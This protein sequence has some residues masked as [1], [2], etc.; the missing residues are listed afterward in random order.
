MASYLV[1][2]GA[3]FIGSHLC[4]ALVAAGHRVSVLDDFSSG[5]PQNID[6]LVGHPRFEYSAGSVTDPALLAECLSR[7][8]AVFHLAAVV[9]MRLVMANPRRTLQINLDGSRL[10]LDLASR[11]GRRVLLASS[12]EVYG[13]SDRLPFRE[14]AELELGPP[15]DGRWVYASSKIAAERLALARAREESLAVS[16]VRLFNTTGP[17]QSDRSGM[18]LPVFA[19]Q[20]LA[21]SPIT[22]HGDGSQRRCFCDVQDVVA[23]LMQL[24][25]HPTATGRVFNL[26]SDQETTVG[27]L[28]ERVRRLAHSDSPIVYVP[29][30]EIWG[31]GFRDVP[32]RVPDLSSLRA[33][34]GFEA[35]TPIDET[36]ARSLAHEGR[37]R[38]PEQSTPLS[39]SAG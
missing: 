23:A 3:G 4:E 35:P 28:A 9:G 25:E 36:I 13:H 29:H 6:H 32:R 22:V 7:C 19:R 1:T 27:E 37:L 26:G 38:A 33:L 21:G 20:A 10:V 2:G 16:V 30:R 34:I 5:S 15:K 31:E 12:S 24:I 11:L 17:R 39:E 14:D 18:V 8:D